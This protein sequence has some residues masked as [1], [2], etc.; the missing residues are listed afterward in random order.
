VFTGSELQSF[1]VYFLLLFLGS[2]VLSLVGAALIEARP[3]ELSIGNI[4]RR[5]LFIIREE[6]GSKL[7]EESKESADGGY[8]ANAAYTMQPSLEGSLANASS[9]LPDYTVPVKN[10]MSNIMGQVNELLE[11]LES[12]QDAIS[13]QAEDHIPD[14][15]KILTFGKSRSAEMFFRAAAKKQRQFQVTHSPVASDPTRQKIT[16]LSVTCPGSCVRVC[17]LLRWA[18]DGQVPLRSWHRYDCHQRCRCFRRHAS[19]LQSV[20]PHTRGDG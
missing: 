1:S 15:A 2:C 17:S 18:G 20:S 11:E 8:E 16:C 10:L 12:A 13:E 3:M 5:V 14:G 6:F 4:V 9:A 19:G 7:A